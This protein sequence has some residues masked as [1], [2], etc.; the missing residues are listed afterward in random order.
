[1]F[2]G[3]ENV[4]LFNAAF[5]NRK[6]K[7]A[8]VPISHYSGSDCLYA[9]GNMDWHLIVRILTAVAATVAAVLWFVSAHIKVP[10]NIDTIVGELQR[11]GYWNSWAA[12][13]SC[14]AAALGALDLIGY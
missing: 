1:V 4:S 5:R 12:S 11:I 8:H 14:V 3:G 9:E 7:A 6:A 10:N 13:A 2:A